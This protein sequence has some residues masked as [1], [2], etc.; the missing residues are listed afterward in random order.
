MSQQTFKV[1]G[2]HCQSCVRVVSGA[3]TALPTVSAVEVDLDADG[4]STVRVETVADLSVEQV[5]AALQEEGE[6]SVVV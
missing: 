3:L 5:R 2:L 6:F 1:T 4:P